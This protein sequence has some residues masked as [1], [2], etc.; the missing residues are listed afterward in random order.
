MSISDIHDEAAK[1]LPPV[2]RRELK[3][4][5]PEEEASI[6]FFLWGDLLCEDDCIDLSIPKQG[7]I[8]LASPEE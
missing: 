4:L 2:E 8:D 1:P 6:R 7:H 5:A 3:G